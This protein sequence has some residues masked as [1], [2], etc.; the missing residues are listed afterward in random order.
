MRFN[1]YYS[2]GTIE[3][4]IKQTQILILYSSVWI[5]ADAKKTIFGSI[6]HKIRVYF[7][8]IF[9]QNINLLRIL[10]KKIIDR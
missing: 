2:D 10:F 9:L 7:L 6:K 1:I 4:K 5:H 3:R 8:F